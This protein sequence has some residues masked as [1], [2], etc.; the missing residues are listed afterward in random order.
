MQHKHGG[1]LSALV[2]PG[3]SWNATPIILLNPNHLSKAVPLNTRVS[4]GFYPLITHL[5]HMMIE[6]TM[7][8]YSGEV[9]K[10]NIFS[11]HP[12]LHFTKICHKG[13]FHIHIRGM[14]SAHENICFFFKDLLISLEG[15]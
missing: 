5:L 4:L 10:Q 8:E 3:S 7:N 6:H 9:E 12:C 15:S 11:P 1:C 14:Q 13:V 2:L